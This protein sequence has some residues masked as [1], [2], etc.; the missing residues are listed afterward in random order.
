MNPGTQKQVLRGVKVTLVIIQGVIIILLVFALQ[1]F[2]SAVTDPQEIPFEEWYGNWAAVLTSSFF[3]LLF[4]FFLTR[5]RRPKEWT[6]AGLTA[7]FFISLFTEMF[8]IPLTIY[9]LAPLLGVEPEIFGMHESHLWAYLL[10]RTGVMPLEAGVYLVMFVS[11]AFLVLGFSLLALGWKTVYRG[12]GELVTAGLY[13]RLRHPQYLGLILVV[14]AF[15][16]MW[17]TL[18]TLLLAPFLIARYF[19]LAREEDRELE[20]AF[21]DEFTRYKDA[22][23]GFIPSLGNK[24]ITTLVLSSLLLTTGVSYAQTAEELIAALG[25][26]RTLGSSSAPVSIVEFSDFQCSFCRKFWSDTLPKLKETYINQG[27]ARFIYRHFAILGKSSEQAAMAVECAG[28]QGK[29]WDY[30]DK[31]FANQGGLAFTQAKLEQYARELGLN[32]ANFKRCL[33]TEKYRKKVERETAVAASLGARGTPTFFVN[34]RLMVG[35]QPF[36]VFQNVINEE[37]VN[38]P[39]KEK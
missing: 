4:L 6:G 2:S 8:G 5:P 19:L 38:S 32:A 9:L 39:S 7:A 35:A 10:S 21:G 18:L 36:K 26:D 20:Q 27:K 12:R 30:H 17:P 13:A 28:E 33:T 29:F 15:L 14:V 22:V 34:G 25:T 1:D 11:T 23:P 31:L 3:F 24:T 16:I 37:L